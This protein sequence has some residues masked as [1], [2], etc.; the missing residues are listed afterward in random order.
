MSYFNRILD[1]HYRRIIE[2]SVIA[3]SQK[4]VLGFKT[5]KKNLFFRSKSIVMYTCSEVSDFNVWVPQ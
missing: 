1:W 4:S 5:V 2:E 3:K